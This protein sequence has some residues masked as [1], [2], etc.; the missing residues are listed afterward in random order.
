MK[1]RTKDQLLADDMDCQLYRLICLAEREGQTDKHWKRVAVA[2]RGARP[3]V[4]IRMHREDL[5]QTI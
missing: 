1:K 5:D 4:R 3:F 2:L